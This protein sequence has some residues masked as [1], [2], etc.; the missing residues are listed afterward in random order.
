M[1]ASM[2]LTVS[3]F[4]RRALRVKAGEGLYTLW[5]YAGQEDLSRVCDLS[6]GGLFIESPAEVNLGAP[7][8]L[9]FLADEGQIRATAVVRHVKPGQGLGLKFIA[10]HGQDSQHLA[11]LIK[12]LGSS[13]RVCRTRAAV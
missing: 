1:A 6:P 13:P 5:N 3:G 2:P 10:V 7:V 8:K 9:D 11:A 12:R 4:R